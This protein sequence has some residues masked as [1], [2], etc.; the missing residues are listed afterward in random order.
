R[1]ARRGQPQPTRASTAR[2]AGA[3]CSR[4]RS[5]CPAP[6][7]RVLVWGRD[8]QSQRLRY[9]VHFSDGGAATRFVD[10][11]LE[12]GAELRDG[13]RRREVERVEQPSTPQV[14]GHAWAR[15]IETSVSSSDAAVGDR[16][17]AD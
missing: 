4:V 10:Q 11:Q 9:V 2:R 1:D 8:W 14:L 13:G 15:L 7:R 12:G 6:E 16:R 5:A 17:A 3:S